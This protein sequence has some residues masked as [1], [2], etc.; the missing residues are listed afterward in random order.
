M[1]HRKNTS[2]PQ[3]CIR[4]Q[5]HHQ[6]SIAHSFSLAITN[7]QPEAEVTSSAEA[8]LTSS[9]GASHL[10]PEW[11][12][13]EPDPSL[14]PALPTSLIL[15]A[16]PNPLSHHADKTD[17]ADLAGS[18]TP[19]SDVPS[20]Q[21]F[22]RKSSRSPLPSPQVHPVTSP[23][24]QPTASQIKLRT[25]L[26]EQD[27]AFRRYIARKTEDD[28]DD[29]FDSSIDSGSDSNSSQA[30][31]MA[32]SPDTIRKQLEDNF[33]FINRGHLKQP[34]NSEFMQKAMQVMKS[35]R[36]SA[37]SDE[38][39]AKF[40]ETYKAYKLSVEA[41]LTYMLVPIMH[42]D[43]LTAQDLNEEGQPQGEF[44]T[45]SFI[46]Q[47]VRMSCDRLFRPYSLPH[48]L[49]NVPNVP[50]SAVIKHFD[51]TKALTTPKPDFSFG[52]LPAK[53]PPAPV[54][55]SVRPVITFLLEVAPIREVFFI[56]ENKSGNGVLMKSQNQALRDVSAVIYAKRR[57]YQE[58]GRVNQGGIDKDTYI[59]AA[60]NDNRTLEFWLAY[61]WLP[62]DCSKVEFCMD[63]IS[64]ID[65][66]LDVVGSDPNT[67][68]NI[69]KPLHN[70]IEW[71]SIGKMP[72]LE[73]FYEELWEVEGQV[74]KRDMESQ[75]AEQGEAEEKGKGKKK[76]KL[77]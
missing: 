38:D 74:F 23:K 35:D 66:E 31:E 69:R 14:H 4:R 11:M 63:K 34:E 5:Q 28:N 39:I 53:L 59:Y 32:T 67:L 54:G 61:A 29:D 77:Y 2:S 76:Q 24:T 25:K 49:M 17:Q 12:I 8:E 57:L 43:K 26:H 22:K 36:H 44:T 20:R 18:S 1:S 19:F 55:M 73:R 52:L 7:N 51:E 21:P 64:T 16:V 33:M 62:S 15:P 42:G 75:K 72:A 30:G 60:T 58:K 10:D 47:G 48:R 50:E 41:T 45:R 46:K 40:D 6:P 37:V 56:W 65:F 3:A 13:V 27:L 68:A 70:I 71:G 9:S